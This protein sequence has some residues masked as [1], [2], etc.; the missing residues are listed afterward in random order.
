MTDIT[1]LT[2]SLDETER[3]CLFLDEVASLYVPGSVSKPEYIEVEY[4]YSVPPRPGSGGTMIETLAETA[5]TRQR[6]YNDRDIGRR[7]FL[8]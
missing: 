5:T 3:P 2:D 6:R 1:T 4:A 8:C 7:V